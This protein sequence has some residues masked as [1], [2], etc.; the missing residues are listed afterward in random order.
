MLLLILQAT[1]TR[2]WILLAGLVALGLAQARPRTIGARRAAL[3]PAMLVMLSLAGVASSFGLAPTAAA[4]W[5]AGIV[6]ALL[7][8]HAWMP[9]PGARWSDSR[10]FVHVAGSWLPLAVI[11][12][13]FA[14]KY[15]AGVSLAMHPELGLRASFAMPFSFAFGIFSGVFAARG[16]QMWRARR[17][18]G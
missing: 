11:L 2:I 5:L 1:P 13:L 6:A 15:A 10:E 17:V 3:L 14:T 16:L 7:A 12:A 18:A 8:T 4:A 9:R